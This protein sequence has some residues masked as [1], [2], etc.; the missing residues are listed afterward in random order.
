MSGLMSTYR[1]E[2]RELFFLTGFSL[3]GASFLRTRDYLSSGRRIW[4][5][6]LGGWLTQRKPFLLANE[7]TE[8]EREA[9]R[10][11]K[12]GFSRV[13]PPNDL[14]LKVADDSGLGFLYNDVHKPAFV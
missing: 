5:R 9:F 2:G 12:N 8:E 3:R 14:P 10:R 1:S 11:G 13:G 4:L 6:R 7:V